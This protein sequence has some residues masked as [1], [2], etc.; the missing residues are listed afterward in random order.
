MCFMI[1]FH[2]QHGQKIIAV[3]RVQELLKLKGCIFAKFMR[4]HMQQSLHF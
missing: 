1:V 4:L 2:F 3:S